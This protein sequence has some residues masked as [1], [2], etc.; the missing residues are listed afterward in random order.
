MVDVFIR[1]L[2]P[3]RPS[4]RSVFGYRTGWRRVY[5]FLSFIAVRYLCVFTSLNF[6]SFCAPIPEGEGAFPR[7][8]EEIPGVGRAIVLI[9]TKKETA[10]A[11]YSISWPPCHLACPE[12]TTITFS[13]RLD[14]RQLPKGAARPVLRRPPA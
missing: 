3:A 5:Y 8:S 6:P 4:R 12:K 13:R 9:K 1:A 2:F 14:N 10:A 7:L 11:P